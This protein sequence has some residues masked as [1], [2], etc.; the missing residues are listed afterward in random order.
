MINGDAGRREHVLEHAQRPNA[1][2]MPYLVIVGPV[3]VAQFLRSTGVIE[4]RR[5]E[6]HPVD[7]I[8][9]DRLRPFLGRPIMNVHRASVPYVH[10]VPG[11]T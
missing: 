3:R 2:S 6:A 7:G 10:R 1:A 5:V 4:R 9:D 8:A 11:T